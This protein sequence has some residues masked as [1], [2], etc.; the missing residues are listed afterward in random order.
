MKLPKSYFENLTASK[1]REYMKYLP[2]L[3]EESTRTFVTL[4]LTFA[5]LSFF[6]LFA[7]NPTL[8]TIIN[9][10]NR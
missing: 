4:A 7:I 2:N 3:K 9:L 8:A 1:Y 5:S 6:G 10:K